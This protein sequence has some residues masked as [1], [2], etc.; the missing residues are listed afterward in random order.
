MQTYG[1][2]LQQDVPPLPDTSPQLT[3]LDRMIFTERIFKS[4][5]EKDIASLVVLLYYNITPSPV[6]ALM[7]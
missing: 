3:Q 7:H 4:I 6:N 1:Y 2:I 5:L